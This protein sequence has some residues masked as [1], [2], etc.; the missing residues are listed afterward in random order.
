[1]KTDN[2][3]KWRLINLIISS[4]RLFFLKKDNIM[5]KKGECLVVSLSKF[6]RV[7]LKFTENLKI[8]S[9]FDK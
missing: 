9:L 8:I 6:R 3:K 5:Y 7:S 4:E 2:N 1:M